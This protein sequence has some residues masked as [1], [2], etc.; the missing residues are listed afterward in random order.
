MK[1]HFWCLTSIRVSVI[2]LVLEEECLE[3]SFRPVVHGIGQQLHGESVHSEEVAHKHH[4][5]YVLN[6]EREWGW[7]ISVLPQKSINTTDKYHL[8]FK[9]GNVEAVV[10]P[11]P[12]TLTV[13]LL[14]WYDLLAYHIIY[15]S[16]DSDSS[17]SYKNEVERYGVL[18]HIS[19]LPK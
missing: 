6:D 8:Y 7:N 1:L 2:Y 5:L 9:L 12:T 17:S 11:P 13:I 16:T 4:S 15:Y 3:L 19:I 10:K 14:I 18:G